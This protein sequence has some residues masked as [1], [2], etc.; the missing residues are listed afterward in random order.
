MSATNL[1]RNTGVPP[2]PLSDCLRFIEVSRGNDTSILWPCLQFENYKQMYPMVN[3]RLAIDANVKRSLTIAFQQRFAARDKSI[4][5]DSVAFLLGK[6][7]PPNTARCVWFVGELLD[8]QNHLPFALDRSGEST[9]CMDAILKQAFPI[10]AT[11]ENDGTSGVA[12]E[13]NAIDSNDSSS[14]SQTPHS[15]GPPSAA[16]LFEGKRTSHS[17]KETDPV[18]DA[19]RTDTLVDDELEGHNHTDNTAKSQDQGGNLQT[20]SL[21]DNARSKTEAP[22]TC[23]VV[24]SGFSVTQPV[25]SKG[26]PSNTPTIEAEMSSSC[27]DSLEEFYSAADAEKEQD[28]YADLITSDHLVRKETHPIVSFPFETS[29][30]TESFVL[31]ETNRSEHER[32]EPKG[33]KKRFSKAQYIN[34]IWKPNELKKCSAKAPRINEG[35]VNRIFKNIRKTNSIGLDSGGIDFAE[36]EAPPEMGYIVVEDCPLSIVGLHGGRNF[37]KKTW[38][39]VVLLPRSNRSTSEVA[40]DG[41]DSRLAMLDEEESLLDD[42]RSAC[43]D[44]DDSSR[45]D[46][47]SCDSVD[48]WCTICRLGL[49]RGDGGSLQLDMEGVS[50]FNGLTSNMMCSAC[51][52]KKRSDAALV[53]GLVAACR[54]DEVAIRRF[55]V[56]FKDN[57]YRKAVVVVTVTFPSLLSDDPGGRSIRSVY[58]TR[59]CSK[60]LHP[61]LQS[62]LSI[63]QSD[64]AALD[65]TMQTVSAAVSSRHSNECA[66]DLRPSLF[67][68]NLSFEDLYLRIQ[69]SPGTEKD[70]KKKGD[71]QRLAQ[72]PDCHIAHLPRQLLVEELA[73]FLR[74]RS[75]DALRCT[76]SYL[77]N[78]LRTVVPGLKLRLYRHQIN[79]LSW[80][81]TRES[82]SVLETDCVGRPTTTGAQSPCG[83]LHR[84]VTGGQTV[85]LSSRP[86]NDGTPSIDIRVNQTTGYELTLEEL[87]ARPRH[88][89]RGGL[90]CDDPGLG[91]TITVLSLI[92]QT[93]GLTTD[94]ASN[95]SK[96]GVAGAPDGDAIF[97]V[98]WRECMTSEFRCPT[99]LKLLNEINRSLKRL[100]NF[101]VAELRRAVGADRYEGDFALFE[102]DVE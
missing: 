53:V 31:G 54:A 76:C 55:R 95:K 40:E 33:L 77:H 80:M 17:L 9:D 84:A 13:T 70:L 21:N 92:L 82:H 96:A 65:A 39:D 28:D 48:R 6:S 45:L 66:Q 49:Q 41:N 64:W 93:S 18:V 19:G 1:N 86:D 87:R 44:D 23:E 79:S 101:P 10:F 2:A 99:L 30:Q 16:P 90:L 91:K 7:L 38:V 14:I 47:S 15:N 35:R 36:Q 62:L 102:E 11:N 50:L 57:A 27:G 74:A 78:T 25:S 12:I 22:K 94:S 61:G 98:Y 37:P 71:T 72:S 8:Y 73:P 75:L 20:A 3:Q 43:N 24:M 58:G 34:M 42:T 59:P 97:Y 51:G 88:V 60:P 67:P 63:I 100:I 32:P 29:A 26:R 56:F 52:N 68:P 85:L 4:K 69:E 46:S 5:D 83:D 89:A 81:R